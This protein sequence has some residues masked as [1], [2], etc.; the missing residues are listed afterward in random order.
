MQGKNYQPYKTANTYSG[1]KKWFNLNRSTMILVNSI[2]DGEHGAVLNVPLADK[3]TWEKLDYIDY[4]NQ[5]VRIYA[6]GGEVGF[7]IVRVIDKKKPEDAV[8]HLNVESSALVRIVNNSQQ[9][10]YCNEPL[11]ELW[12]RRVVELRKSK[13]TS[14]RKHAE[15]I[16]KL[17]REYGLKIVM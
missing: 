8:P 7:K 4:P 13:N 1:L 15:K 12:N 9:V 14:Y 5:G 3:G 11:L 10:V 2:R 17:I 6:D 16:E